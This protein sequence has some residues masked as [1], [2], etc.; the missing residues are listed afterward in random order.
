MKKF[1]CTLMITTMLF[2]CSS[3]D[4]EKSSVQEETTVAT[5][6]TT[7]IE[8]IDWLSMS[9]TEIS[10]KIDSMTDAELEIVGGDITGDEM[11]H[12]R[13]ALSEEQRD[14]LA[15]YYTF[16]DAEE[17]ETIFDTVDEF[18]A[19]SD[20]Q[21]IKSQAET[22]YL[23]EFDTERYSVTRIK[24]LDGSYEYRL[25]DNTEDINITLSVIYTTYIRDIKE[26]QEMLPYEKNVLTT[27]EAWGKTYD[28]YLITSKYSD[29]ENYSLSYLPY[30]GYHVTISTGESYMPTD[31]ILEYFDDFELVA[32]S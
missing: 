29:N 28:V 6:A 26:I 31:R 5:E 17:P 7:S 13:E 12:I 20:Y 10:D 27:A 9:E 14:R 18:K 2:G 30:E 15:P 8:E 1:L 22:L 4:T 16:I 25:H 11:W 3:A 24:P 19:S 21:A 23:P 32:E